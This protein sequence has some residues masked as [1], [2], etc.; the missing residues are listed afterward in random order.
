M[1]EMTP[2]SD[3]DTTAPARRR[4]EPRAVA[5]SALALGALAFPDHTRMSPGRRHLLRLARSAYVG[6]YAWDT[7][8]RTP[9][10]EVPAPVFGAVSGAAAAL[11]TAPADEAVD[12][13]VADRLRSWGMPHPRLA[14][15]LVGA[16]VGAVLALENQSRPA[17]GDED[18]MLEPADFFEPIDVPDHARAL[19]EVLLDAPTSS[20]EDTPVPAGLAETAATL[21][22]QLDQARA[23]VLRDQPLSTDVHFEVPAEAPRVVPHAQGWPVRAHFEAGELPLVIELW[24]GD[25]RLAHLSIM[26]RDDDLAEDDERWGTDILDVLE[27]WPTPEEARLVMETAEGS[28]PVG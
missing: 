21:R 28:R 20:G 18:E 25:G 3:P 13:W 12:G 19:V 17:P 9:M 7:V 11:V 5:A 8:R 26:L 10:F 24:I 23:S 1:S 6:W 15:A 27:T 4:V 2:A 22:V 16:G 14:L